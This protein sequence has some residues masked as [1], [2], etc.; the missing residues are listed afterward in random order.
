MKKL[1]R[2]ALVI[3]LI[4]LWITGCVRPDKGPSPFEGLVRETPVEVQPSG[5]QAGPDFE[6]LPDSELVYG[7]AL[8]AFSLSD[9]VG[10]NLPALNAYSEL[11]DERPMTGTEI[12]EKVSRDYSVN[13]RLLLSLLRNRSGQTLNLEDPF[14]ADPAYKGLFRQLS[15]AANTLN[16]GYYTRRVNALDAL[17]LTDGVVVEIPEQLNAGSAAIQ[18]FYSLLLGYNDWLTAVGLLGVHVDYLAWFGSP[19]EN[20]VEPLIPAGLAQPELRLPYA[21]GEGWYFTAGPHSAWGD[22]A[23]WAALDFAPVAPNEDDWGCYSSPNWVRALADG[24][25]V[26]VSDGLVVQDLDDDSFEGSGWTVLYMHVAE[27]ERVALGTWLNAGDPIGH[28]SCE[29]GPATGTHLHI[30]RRYNGEWIPADQDI[31]FILSGWESAGFGV[32][33]DGSLTKD[34]LVIE[35][36]G[37]PTD[38]N[39]VYP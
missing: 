12:V 15:W 1:F 38:E 31:P 23:A 13:P 10:E 18:Y 33:Y 34:S 7:P 5:P 8:A 29:G 19:R 36:S 4:S 22:G 28:P 26:R 35:A 27:S 3:L 30:A 2:S 25:V 9:F 11:V 14:L 24:P 32:E 21:D 20:V 39:R 16:R 17:T 6:I 37:F